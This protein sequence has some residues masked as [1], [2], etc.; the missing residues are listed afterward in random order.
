MNLRAK[1]EDFIRIYEQNL[2][3]SRTYK[4]A[5]EKAEK[6]HEELCGGRMYSDH[7]TFR[8]VYNRKHKKNKR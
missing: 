4:E 5:Y 8:V 7:N 3:V 6:K 2:P 1:P